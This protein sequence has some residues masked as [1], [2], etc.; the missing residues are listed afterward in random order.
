MIDV[1][2]LDDVARLLIFCFSR[3]CIRR[4]DYFSRLSNLWYRQKVDTI[5]MPI[6]TCNAGPEHDC[7]DLAIN[8]LSL[9]IQRVS[10]QPGSVLQRTSLFKNN[11]SN[12]TY[13]GS[14]IASACR[15][16]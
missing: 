7:I 11:G 12:S 5:P 4:S 6:L 10:G 15:W 9:Y 1:L 8:I 16:G 14:R 3:L 2:G 13:P